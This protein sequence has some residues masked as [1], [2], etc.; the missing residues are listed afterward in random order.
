MN[1][2]DAYRELARVRDEM[3]AA[4]YALALA[5]AQMAGGLPGV[6]GMTY[7]AFEH[8]RACRNNLELTYFLRLFATFESLLR[9]FW[10]ASVRVTRPDLSVLVDSIAARRG[11]DDDSR[12]AVHDIRETRND[13]MHRNVAAMPSDFASSIRTCG[14]FLRWLP[15]SW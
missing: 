14:L 11:I 3:D 6:R 8:L 12:N 10:V 2:D 13:I 4:R 9:S 1:R 15:T 5:E 7:P